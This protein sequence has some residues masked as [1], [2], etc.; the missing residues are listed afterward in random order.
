MRI[1]GLN[2]VQLRALSPK[3]GLETLSLL[4]KEPLA[5]GYVIYLPRVILAGLPGRP[6]ILLK[7]ARVQE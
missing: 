2:L 1:D 7:E 6:Y 3:I 5:K 4:A